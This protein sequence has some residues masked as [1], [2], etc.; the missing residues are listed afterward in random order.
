MVT[1]E[2]N[3]AGSFKNWDST[4]MQELQNSNK[5]NRIGNTLLFEDDSIKVWSILLKPGDQLPFHKHTKNY[6][7]ICLTQGVAISHHENGRIVEIKYQ[8]GDLSYY[9]HDTKGDFVH[10]LKNTGN[11]LLKF[12]TIEYK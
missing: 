7:W 12:N 2:L 1:K 11:L 4:K 8:K 9:D 10:D 6:T 3:P 5:S